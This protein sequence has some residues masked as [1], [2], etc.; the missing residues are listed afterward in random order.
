MSRRESIIGWAGF[1]VVGTIWVLYAGLE[2]TLS[3][4][5]GLYGLGDRLSHVGTLVIDPIALGLLLFA[6]LRRRIT[7]YVWLALAAGLITTVGPI[8]LA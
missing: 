5:V 1:I 4:S 8:L 3:R 2:I 6:M 7:W